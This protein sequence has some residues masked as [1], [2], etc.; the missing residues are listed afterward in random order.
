MA[1]RSDVRTSPDI[2]AVAMSPMS[3]A[4][5]E[6]ED[7]WEHLVDD[8]VA[9]EPAE[10]DD[11][12]VK[13]DP[14]GLPAS[15][16]EVRSS[17]QDLFGSEVLDAMDSTDA[18]PR[19]LPSR[20]ASV[21]EDLAVWT[22]SCE[23]SPSPVDL[24]DEVP[25]AEAKKKQL[26]LIQEGVT[27]V[28]WL[29][30]ITRGPKFHAT[31]NVGTKIGEGGFGKVFLA[32]HI[33]TG[34][35]RAVKRLKKSA[36]HNEAQQNELEAL[37]SLDHPHIVKMVEYYDE[38]HYLYLVF[39]LCQGP[40]LFERVV[41][42]VSGRMGEYEAS[43]ALRHMLKALQCC[44]AQYRGHYDIKPEN[45]MYASTELDELMMIDLG[46]S[47]G[48][49]SHRGSKVKGTAAY[50]APECRRG[51]YG[52]ECD[53]WSCG[54]V[55]FVM[56]TGQPFLPN[57]PAEKIKH[58]IEC[59]DLIRWRLSRAAEAFSLSEEAQDLLRAMLQHD[60]HARPTVKEA[61]NHEFNQKHYDLEKKDPSRAASPKG[62][63]ANEV[64]DALIRHLR[65]VA[66]EPRLKRIA[67]LI[68]THACGASLPQ[69]LA[70]RKLDQHGYGELSVGVLERFHEARGLPVPKDLRAI[71]RAIDFNRIGYI[72]YTMFLSATLSADR[73]KDESLC[74]TTFGMLDRGGDGVIDAADLKNIFGRPNQDAFDICRKAVE[75]VVGNGKDTIS[76]EQFC[77]L[78]A[79]GITLA[80]TK[81][82]AAAG[83]AKAAANG[84]KK[85]KA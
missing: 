2:D 4:S 1:H 59:R 53:I 68:M 25:E 82:P 37:L 30:S 52:P 3:A 14:Y 22:P 78:M 47:S 67:R 10:A 48:F 70:F 65:M 74:R 18:P 80:A 44:H 7:F 12:V 41:T 69:R 72:T 57:V 32:T 79:S 51:V 63:R 27:H 64:L 39:E 20:S 77:Q 84:C 8:D 85:M 83:S 16:T 24:D 60:R 66:K 55:L 75:E 46:L 38:D 43:V 28:A 50:L 6:A 23:P 9:P 19:V 11:P 36:K 58:E 5:K 35:K 76:F 33:Q 71:F 54:I 31:Y 42:A 81:R 17:L 45:F 29:H 62:K 61:L 34:T 21:A 56:L 73:L 13:E 40:D 49:D 26:N 15:H